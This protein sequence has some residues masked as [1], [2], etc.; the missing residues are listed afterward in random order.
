MWPANRIGGDRVSCIV[1]LASALTAATA[2]ATAQTPPDTI[3]LRGTVRDFR[4][5]H[6]DFDVPE[7][8]G[9]GHVAGNSLLIFDASGV[10]RLAAG[11]YRVTTQW[12]NAADDGIAPH[13][14]RDGRGTA[15]VPV[16]AAPSI[17]NN[18]Q[19]DSFDSNVGPYGGGNIGPAPTF[20][21]D[22]EMP[23]LTEPADLPTLSPQVVY[24]GNG[25]SVLSESVH[26]NRFALLNRHRLTINGHLTILSEEEFTIDNHCKL[27]IPDG[28]SLTIYVKGAFTL[29]NNI[30][31]NMEGG[32]PDRLIIYNLGETPIVIGNNVG[33]YGQITSPA[34]PL[35]ILNNGDLYGNYTGLAVQ[36]DNSAGLHIDGGSARSM[37]GAVIVD[38]RGTAGGSS[39]AAV[40]SEVTF[41]EWFQDVLGANLSMPHTITLAR[42]AAGVYESVNRPFHPADDRLFG[43]EEDAHNY[44][45]TFE[46][47]FRFVFRQCQGQF[48]RL[49]GSDDIYLFLDNGL[50]IDLGGIAHGREQ[51]IELDRLNLVDGEEYAGALFYAH[52]HGDDASL[53]IS[54]NIE[55]IGS[56]FPGVA[57]AAFD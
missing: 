30:E 31:M 45:F 48:I 34:A 5:A 44:N 7:S 42:N 26:C 49:G 19:V 11:G 18:P 28:S 24:N 51:L 21:A 17:V 14:Y 39:A 41:G 25:A 47:R 22:S 12:R 29:S 9:Y 56:G 46:A 37:C 10:P 3:P 55:L 43:N 40:T 36:L 32:D 50:V 52:R 35:Q 6:P 16:V 20:I 38:Q 57:S 54:T 15:V 27:I 23:V 2:D 13:L 53:T 4:K 33:V 8:V 1:A